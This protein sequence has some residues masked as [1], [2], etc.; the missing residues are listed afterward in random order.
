MRAHRGK[1]LTTAESPTW[2]LRGYAGALIGVVKLGKQGFLNV[3]YRETSGEDGFIITAFIS[4]KVNR[5]NII[6]PKERS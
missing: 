6:W 5:G 1:V 3:V 4:R 2:I